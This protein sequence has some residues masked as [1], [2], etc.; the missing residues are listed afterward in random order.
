MLLRYS[1]SYLWN[2]TKPS[3]YVKYMALRCELGLVRLREYSPWWLK[4]LVTRYLW[5]KH[6]LIWV[7]YEK[8]LLFIMAKLATVY[9]SSLNRWYS[10]HKYSGIHC[11]HSNNV[12][13]TV[14]DECTKNSSIVQLATLRFY[15]CETI[16][17]NAH[18]KCRNS[19]IT[20]SITIDG[21]VGFKQ[22]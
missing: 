11:C 3:R 10:Q 1:W 16:W 22:N 18:G 5:T 19:P 2:P 20:H 7:P 8:H 6:P 21:W 14:M 12:V 17:L 13:Q 15:Q 9:S 4:W